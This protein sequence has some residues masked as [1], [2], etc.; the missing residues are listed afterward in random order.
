MH[1]IMCHEKG[2]VVTRIPF[3]KPYRQVFQCRDVKI[4]TDFLQNFIDRISLENGLQKILVN[5]R[6]IIKILVTYIKS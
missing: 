3:S 2:A 4:N 6:G 5:S 1:V